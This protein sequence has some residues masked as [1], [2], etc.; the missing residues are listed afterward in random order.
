MPSHVVEPRVV[1]PKL[2]EF[3]WIVDDRFVDHD[4]TAI[5][6]RMRRTTAEDQLA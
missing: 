4:G 3:R 6:T 1:T 2:G 5:D